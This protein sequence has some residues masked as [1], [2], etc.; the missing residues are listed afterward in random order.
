VEGSFSAIAPGP[1]PDALAST[2]A[3]GRC[4]QIVLSK[5][6]TAYRAWHDGGA[7]EFGAFWSLEKP[8]G[9]LQTRMDSALRPEWGNQASEYSTITA[10]A[11]TRVY[12]GRVGS[13][14][15]AWV[16]GNSQILIEGGPQP[17]WKTGGG[18]LE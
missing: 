6:L 13:Q 8:A 5:P 18:Y 14:G 9:A 1:L 12:A 15:G 4:E 10:P 7:R 2:Y 3:G 17:S 16:G 11:G